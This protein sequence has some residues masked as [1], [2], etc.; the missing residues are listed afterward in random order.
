MNREWHRA[1][2]IPEKATL[3]ERIK[4]HVAHAKKCGCRPIP[5]KIQGEMKKRQGRG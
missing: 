5:F 4:W 1:H 3:E 2:K